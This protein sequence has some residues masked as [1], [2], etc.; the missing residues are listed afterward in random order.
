MGELLHE[1]DVNFETEDPESLIYLLLP[2]VYLNMMY[3]IYME[4][5]ICIYM[6]IY[7][8]THTYIYIYIYNNVHWVFI[9]G[10]VAIQRYRTVNNSH[11]FLH[12]GLFY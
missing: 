10:I 9:G 2:A 4:M 3:A 6:Y 8:H 5:H 12:A 11:V 1:M 7:T